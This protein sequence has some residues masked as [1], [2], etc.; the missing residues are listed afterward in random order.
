MSLVLNGKIQDIHPASTRILR[1]RNIQLIRAY[2]DELYRQLEEHNILTRIERLYEACQGLEP[3]DFTPSIE[4]ELEKI[5][6][7]VT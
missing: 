7:T 1:S 5:D 6:R 4:K 2:R 3:A